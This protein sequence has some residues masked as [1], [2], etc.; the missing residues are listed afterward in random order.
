MMTIP[1]V[2]WTPAKGRRVIIAPSVQTERKEYFMEKG[3]VFFIPHNRGDGQDD[4]LAKCAIL[5]K[6]KNMA[7]KKAVEGVSG[8]MGGLGFLKESLALGVEGVIQSVFGVVEQG[9]LTL[10]HKL[11]RCFALFFF[12]LLAGVFLL[13][14]V[15]RVLNAVY[16]VPGV[17]EIV[18]GAF[19]LAGVLL[20]YMIQQFNQVK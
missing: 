7:T 5:K 14:G 1:E 20:T 3:I 4:M 18:V 9:T 8:L 10:F 19:I 15:A 17:G 16:H 6:K 2:A 12:S 11:L 13:V